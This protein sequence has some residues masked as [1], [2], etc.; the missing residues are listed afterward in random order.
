[1]AIRMVMMGLCVVVTCLVVA[2]PYAEAVV[3]CARVAANFAPCLPYLTNGGGAVPPGCCTGILALNA[4][5]T[6][7]VARQATCNCLRAAAGSVSGINFGLAAGLPGLCG[8]S[9]PFNIS[10]NTD[11]SLYVHLFVKLSLN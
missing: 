6:T 11:C 10:L 9:I 5:A 2:A 7:T 1:M 4:S 3:T 8:V